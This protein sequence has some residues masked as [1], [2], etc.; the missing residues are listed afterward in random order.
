[1]MSKETIKKGID[2]LFKMY[3]D[4][5][6]DALINH[7][8]KGLVIDFI[9]GEPLL[10]M[11]VITYGSKYFLDECIRRDHIW[12]TNFRFN[13]SSNGIRYF[14]ADVQEYLKKFGQFTHLNITLDGPKELHDSCRVDANGNGSFDIVIKAYKDWIEK[15]GYA[16]TKITI[17]PENL[18]QLNTIIDFFV[19]LGCQDIHA[20]PIFEREWTVEDAKIYYQQLKMLADKFLLYPDIELDLFGETYCKPLSPDNNKNWCGGTGEMVS[21]D[22]D[23]IAY[24]CIRYMETSL[25]EEATPITIG[26]V[27]GIYITKQEK[28]ILNNFKNITR[29]SQSTDE[30]YYCPIASGCAWCSAWNYQKLGSVNKRYTGICWMHRARSLANSYYYNKLYRLQG[31]EKRFPVYLPYTLALKIVSE[32]EYGELIRLSLD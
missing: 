23:G 13:I 30:C 4:N 18:P 21:F 22:P 26:S 1:M 11:E 32:K 19:D 9:G 16:S 27:D 28:E 6:E 3:D 15:N 5:N 20:N 10:N 14:D 24:P 12:L 7:H 8:T 25:G 31:S 2:L 17:A 29:R